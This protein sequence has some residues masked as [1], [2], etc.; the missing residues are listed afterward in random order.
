VKHVSDDLNPSAMQQHLIVVRGKDGGVLRARL[1]TVAPKQPAPLPPLPSVL[2]V[3]NQ[4]TQ[5]YS[6]VDLADTKA[7]FFVRSYEGS[8]V[9][10]D[11]VNFFSGH[12][13]VSN[14]WVTVRMTDG[15]VLEGR[16]ANDINLLKATGF[17][18]WPTDAFSNNLLVFVPKGSVSEFHI[19]GLEVARAEKSALGYGVEQQAAITTCDDLQPSRP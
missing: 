4:S 14:L 8:N 3:W 1:E 9:W 6:S 13:L 15:E 7:V 18:L 11:Q 12:G 2:E 17:W 16:I 10:H 5:Q 19:M